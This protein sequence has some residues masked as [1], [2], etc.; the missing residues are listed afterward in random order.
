MQLID[1]LKLTLSYTDM[2]A[3]FNLKMQEQHECNESF[4]INAL[5]KKDFSLL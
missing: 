1:N 3:F 5:H 4:L 2:H